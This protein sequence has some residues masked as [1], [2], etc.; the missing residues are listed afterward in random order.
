MKLAYWMGRR[1]SGK[2]RDRE[3][4]S[5]VFPVYIPGMGNGIIFWASLI[6][7]TLTPAGGVYLNLS[8]DEGLFTTILEVDALSIV[9]P[10]SSLTSMS[11]GKP[12]SLTT[13]ILMSPGLGNPGGIS[14]VGDGMRL[15]T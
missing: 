2:S 3:T 15:N 14:V 9:A 8:G 4:F 5:G 10:A 13:V 1:L 12:V 7:M 11:A 6:S